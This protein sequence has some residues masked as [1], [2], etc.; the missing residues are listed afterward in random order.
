MQV[1]HAATS[2][3][4]ITVNHQERRLDSCQPHTGHC[5]GCQTTIPLG[6]EQVDQVRLLIKARSQHPQG[7]ERRSQCPAHRPQTDIA[8]GHPFNLLHQTTVFRVGV[9]W[10]YDLKIMPDLLQFFG[11]R[12]HPG[13]Q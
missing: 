2:F 9:G 10:H 13:L 3:T 7:N 6:L 1:I 12:Q 8:Q 5:H 11:Q 4:V